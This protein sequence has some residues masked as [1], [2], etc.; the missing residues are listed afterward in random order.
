MLSN[1]TF[2]WKPEVLSSSKQRHLYAPTSF[3]HENCVVVVVVIDMLTCFPLDIARPQSFFLS[4]QSTPTSLSI[5][6]QVTKLTT[7]KSAT[8]EN[9]RQE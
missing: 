1:L 7:L 8:L 2:E 6:G 3:P 9:S 5:K 4:N